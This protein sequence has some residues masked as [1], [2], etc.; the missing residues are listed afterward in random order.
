M[1]VG[2]GA[3]TEQVVAEYVTGHLVFFLFLLRTEV[4]T[5]R[6]SHWAELTVPL[7]TFCWQGCLLSHLGTAA[8]CHCSPHPTPNSAWSLDLSSQTPQLQLGDQRC[9]PKSRVHTAWGESTCALQHLQLFQGC[10]PLLLMTPSH[11]P[12]PEHPSQ[13]PGV[14]SLLYLPQVM[15]ITPMHPSMK[16]WGEIWTL[17]KRLLRRSNF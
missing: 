14:D 13:L 11:S 16:F 15:Y 1:W 4:G 9:L 12:V 5:C 7:G 10:S 6:R 17:M 8:S 3:S 2:F